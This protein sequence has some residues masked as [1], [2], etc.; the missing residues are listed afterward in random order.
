MKLK[1]VGFANYLMLVHVSF[2]S[3]NIVSR[4]KVK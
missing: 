3:H 1:L 2:L 4:N